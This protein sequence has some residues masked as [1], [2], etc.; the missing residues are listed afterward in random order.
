MF[1]RAKAKI[2][3][4]PDHRRGSISRVAFRAFRIAVAG[5][6]ALGHGA[7]YMHKLL[8]H[9]AKRCDELALAL[10]WAMTMPA[11]RLTIGDLARDTAT[12]HPR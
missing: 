1:G 11:K 12:K 2:K 9:Q 3:P 10:K 8:E 4:D 6:G 7:V 5:A